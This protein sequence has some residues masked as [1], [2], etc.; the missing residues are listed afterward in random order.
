MSHMAQ[1]KRQ[2]LDVYAPPK[3]TVGAPVVLFA[4]GGGWAT[5][6]KSQ[7]AIKGSTY[8]NHGVLFICT[9]YQLAPNVMH[10]KQVQDIASAFAWVKAHAKEYGGDPNKIYV[11]GHS[12]GAQLVDLLA[13]NDKYLAEKGLKLSDI[14]GCI[15]LD[16]A[17]LNLKDRRSMPEQS[18]AFQMV[19]NAFGK[20][21][22]VLADAS[23]ML[24]L[25]KGK[26]YPPFLMIASAFRRDSKAAH[27]EFE[28]SVQAV[29][30][31]IT[32]TY[33]PLDHKGV[34]KAAGTEGTDVF[35]QCL[36]FIGAQ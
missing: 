3:G 4:H 25:V 20:D 2:K 6:N 5:G 27:F 21:P 24:N 34:N 10:P 16:T 36:A 35:K 12:A 31:T 26:K 9:N 29:G 33:V 18:P 28:K 30:G 13:T 14:K 23:P 11:M 8:A 7:H 17:S 19:A 22:K 15:S 32:T 1:Q